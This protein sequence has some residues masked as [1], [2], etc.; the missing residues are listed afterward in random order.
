V[1]VIELAVS[2]VLMASE[3]PRGKGWVRTERRT[4]GPRFSCGHHKWMTP[5]QQAEYG[6]F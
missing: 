6:H 4:E 2:I 3:R 1:K 5:Y